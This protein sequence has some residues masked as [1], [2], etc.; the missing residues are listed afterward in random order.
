MILACITLS[1]LSAVV[2][3]STSRRSEPDIALLCVDTFT[4]NYPRLLCL[5]L[6]RACFSGALLS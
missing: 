6:S 3:T 1:T 2:H 5:S 4:N